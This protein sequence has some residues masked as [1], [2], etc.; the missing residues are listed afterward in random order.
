LFGF[1]IFKSRKRSFQSDVKIKKY[2]SVAF[3]F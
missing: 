3:G 1:F 2:E